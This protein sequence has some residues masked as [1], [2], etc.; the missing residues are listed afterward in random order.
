VSERPGRT[1]GGEKV[2]KKAEQPTGFAGRLRVL[3]EAAGLTQQQLAEKAGFYKFTIAKFEQG[4]QE[5]TWPTVLALAAA[6]GV[7][8][9]AFQA[10][11]DG[12]EEQPRR[13]PGRP[14]KVK[15]KAAGEEA[16]T[17][18]AETEPSPRQPSRQGAEKV[19]MSDQGAG[20]ERGQRSKK[21]SQKRKAKD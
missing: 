5:P 16:G 15:A 6:L 4:I 18:E 2:P 19:E 21:K 9:R 17:V 14:P 13:G 8:C 10:G 12:T 11:N 7:D 20:T 3:R 1:E